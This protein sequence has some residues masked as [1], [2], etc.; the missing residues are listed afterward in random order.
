M[1]ANCCFLLSSSDDFDDLLPLL[2]ISNRS[3]MLAYLFSLTALTCA[4]TT[5][6][7]VDSGTNLL[8][9][10]NIRQL[11]QTKKCFNCNLSQVNLAGADL[12]GVNLR[13]ANLQEADLR[14]ANLAGA[15]LEWADLRGANL[16]GANLAGA[17]LGNASLHE[18]NFHS[19][20]LQK[21]NLRGTDLRD[22]NLSHANLVQASI[23][24]MSRT[25]ILCNTRML[26]GTISNRGCS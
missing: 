14:G 12:T 6:L 23:E 25:A 21:S 26:D 17:N 16:A 13:S 10:H 22:A 7:L 8:R 9:Q 2:L 11:Q 15:M 24:R 19:S 18:T 20:N 5:P 4:L 1:E 3:F